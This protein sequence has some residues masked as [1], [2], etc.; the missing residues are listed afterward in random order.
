M[1]ATT[2]QR[3]LR[4]SAPARFSWRWVHVAVAAAMMVAT[5]PGRTQGLGLFTEPILSSLNL[6]R[7]SYG[8]INLWA[9]L[10][11]ALFCLPCGWLLDRVGTRAVLLG[12][13]SALGLVVLG[14]SR[15]VGVG[16]VT[17]EL[18]GGFA[19]TLV[20]D[21]FILILLTRGLGQSA[22]SVVSLALIGRSAAG[23]TGL[24]MGVYAC[25]T[26]L[27]FIAAFGVLR[28]VIKQEPGEWR[29]P[30]AGIGIGV[31]LSG[32]I[33]GW[34]VRN[35]ELDGEAGEAAL[36]DKGDQS[37]TLGQSLAAPAFWSFALATSFYGMVVAGT[38]LFGESII[39]ERGFPKEIFLNITIIGIPFGLAANLLGGWA[40]TRIPTSRLLGGGMALFALALGCFPL[41]ESKEAIYAYATA[42]TVAGG[43]VTV[44][45]FT[46]WRQAF[47]TAHL[48]RI[49]GAA[50][51]LTVVFSALG[52]L[53]FATAK[54]RLHEYTPLFPVLAG[55]AAALAL[56]AWFA[57]PPRARVSFE[58]VEK[59]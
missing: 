17:L 34:L 7:E 8:F 23:R 28:A 12:V 24:A 35:R 44:C 39:A 21:A 1:S 41:I 48:G 51:L 22:L 49:Q 10:L 26:S 58:N 31:L 9:T 4:K 37:R 42:L 50:Q 38:S 30:W 32:I 33:S 59:S 25:L 20:T 57:R 27:G 18:P 46:I 53:L 5:L 47:G 54:T 19:S 36:A 6:D 16:R 40:A 55:G 3:E 2:L 43:I 52:P 56:F 13:T 11:G 14:M 45:F 15:M 29:G